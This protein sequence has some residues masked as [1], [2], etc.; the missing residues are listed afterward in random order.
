M[1]T[2]EVMRELAALVAAAKPFDDITLVVV[3]CQPK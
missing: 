2:A 3:S 1:I